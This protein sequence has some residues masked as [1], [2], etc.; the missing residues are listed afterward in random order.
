MCARLLKT[1]LFFCLTLA[2]SVKAEDSSSI[3]A[4][5]SSFMRPILMDA[6]G[7]EV[8]GDLLVDPN[9]I[10]LLFGTETDPNVL[11]VKKQLHLLGTGDTDS[12]D[13]NVVDARAD[14]IRLDGGGDVIVNG[15][16]TSGITSW[17]LAAGNSEVKNGNFLK[18]LNTHTLPTQPS[19]QQYNVWNLV[20]GQSYDI[21]YDLVTDGGADFNVVSTISA[22][23][24]VTIATDLVTSTWTRFTHSFTSTGTHNTLVFQ[25]DGIAVGRWFG[26]DNVT[27][28]YT[29]TN[30]I[31]NGDFDSATTSWLGATGLETLSV[32]TD[33]Q[34]GGYIQ[35]RN[36]SNSINQDIAMQQYNEWALTAGDRYRLSMYVRTNDADL[37][38]ID[39]SVGYPKQALDTIPTTTA[40]VFHSII[41]TATSAANTLIFQASGIGV[42]PN[43]S[44][45]LDTVKL[46]HLPITVDNFDFKEAVQLD[47]EVDP[48]DFGA[49]GDGDTDDTVAIQTALDRASPK[50][51]RFKPGTYVA[52]ALTV[53]GDTIVDLGGATLKKRPYD[54]NDPNLPE[55]TGN[56]TVFWSAGSAPE[57]E[58]APCLL[59]VTGNNVIIRNGI[60]DGDRTN[61]TY[62]LAAWGGS[63]SVE[64]NR[65]G[66]LAS[67]S[68]IAAVTNLTVQNVTF[69]NMYGDAIVTEYLTDFLRVEDCTDVNAGNLFLFTCGQWE[70][71]YA[72]QGEV[73]VSRNNTSGPRVYGNV[74]N[75]GVID[76]ATH[77]L[78]SD[79]IFDA[80][81]VNGGAVKIQNHLVA[82]VENNIFNH[83]HLTPQNGVGW[84]GDTLSITGNIFITY[85][86]N[87]ASCGISGG[88]STYHLT[89]VV[90]NLFY[91]S[92]CGM[93][94]SSNI[95]NI[96]GNSWY[97]DTNCVESPYN[98]FSAI[99]GG[100]DLDDA[101]GVCTIAHNTVEMGGLAR[102]VFHTSPN[103]MGKMYMLD[104]DVNGVD[105]IF[106]VPGQSDMNDSNAVEFIVKDNRFS[107]YRTVGRLNISDF[108]EVSF[109][110]NTFKD[111]DTATPTNLVGY[112]GRQLYCTFSA[113]YTMG[114]LRLQDNH[115]DVSNGTNYGY[116]IDFSDSIIDRVIIEDEYIRSASGTYS[117]VLGG[118]TGTISSLR[119]IGNQINEALLIQPTVTAREHFEVNGIAVNDYNSVIVTLDP[120]SMN[121]SGDIET[122]PFPDVVLGDEITPIAL[123]YEM[124]GIM[125]TAYV[126]STG[127]AMVVF[128]KPSAGAVDLASG[129]YKLIQRKH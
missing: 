80:S 82:Q 128:Y 104:N 53:P 44:F 29:G 126:K 63:F 65:C 86:P 55:F 54:A 88:R 101:S 98:S 13:V 20:A 47:Y 81:L 77:L 27:L 51:V 84:V 69:K 35:C 25:P 58:I 103:R 117:I 61:E 14:T 121:A 32:A 97:C 106:V 21:S 64:G 57:Y 18:V 125:M 93:D 112:T 37:P 3:P 102:H 2:A 11:S 95:T 4:R 23:G 100:A 12:N 39:V 56:S 76:H 31:L 52:F 68:A 43:E 129:S 30:V 71:P 70:S 45:Q 113:G 73:I 42:D 9:W 46:E 114:T 89:E 122:V 50:V 16:F 111:I 34:S 5:V 123:D 6:N 48:R 94:R 96:V 19:C 67:H 1:L 87:V 127:I 72:H 24:S 120:N 116:Q 118:A 91:N 74:P 17:A 119:Y 107:G 110:G 40:W 60:I 49:V 62:G 75:T 36:D 108:N 59:Y 83:L 8:L 28:A 124:Q 33:G 22:P 109:V 41:F 85:E 99:S 79:N 90:G 26:L 78:L 10:G 105:N 7:V 115:W 38:T 15:E 92:F 66:I